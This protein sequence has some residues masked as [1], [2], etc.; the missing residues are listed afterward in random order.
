MIKSK[1]STKQICQI[2]NVTRETLRHYERLGLLNPYIN[3]D[4]GYREYSYW[5]VSTMVDILKY[6]SL[7][8][9]LS[10]TKDA[11]FD[12]DFPTI[13][14]MLED[15]TDYYTNLITKY[16]LLLDKAKRDFPYLRSAM[17]HIGE[18]HEADMVDLFYIPYT[19]KPSD[20][21]FP[22]MQTAFDNSQFFSTA[23]CINGINHGMECYGL[24]TEKNFADFLKVSNGIII[25]K[26]HIVSQIIDV[27]GRDP[28]DET[29]ASDF[30]S[31][32]TRM[33]SREF[34]TIYAI[35]ISR[36]YD[37]EKRYHQY[38]FVFS[39]LD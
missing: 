2:F 29:I 38:Y 36:F 3:P 12:M 6:R 17:N 31:S 32:I 20:E 10:D 13:V 7:G 11:I 25:E 26:S 21:N 35:L 18:I 33:Y 27:I 1:Y 34:D 39:K 37:K 14:N 24:I 8:F 16:Q 22:S 4:N 9:S 28:I 23:L 19:T 15:H 5:D 30:K